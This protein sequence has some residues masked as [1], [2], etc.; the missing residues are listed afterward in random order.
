MFPYAAAHVKFHSFFPQIWGFLFDHSCRICHMICMKATESHWVLETLL[1]GTFRN[2]VACLVNFNTLG[3]HTVACKFKQLYCES[4]HIHA[5][6]RNTIQE[7]Q[8]I[9][10]T[11]IKLK[12]ALNRL[13][14]CTLLIQYDVVMFN[15]HNTVCSKMQHSFYYSTRNCDRY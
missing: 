13:E 3:L 14:H 15:K 7:I 5:D 11:Q 8:V 12:S 6:C 2:A 9:V 4:S 1:R 10:G